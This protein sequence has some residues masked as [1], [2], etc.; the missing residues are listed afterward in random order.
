[1][2]R[3]KSP[4]GFLHFIPSQPPTVEALVSWTLNYAFP[5]PYNWFNVHF[6]AQTWCISCPFDDNIKFPCQ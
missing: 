6:C 3:F 4:E 1:M 2:T 5:V